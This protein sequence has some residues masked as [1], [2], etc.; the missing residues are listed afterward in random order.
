MKNLSNNQIYFL[1]KKYDIDGYIKIKNLL[2]KDE[3]NEIKSSLFKFI[4]KKSK[5]FSGRDVSFVKNSKTINSIH[6][7]KKWGLIKKIQNNQ[8]IK[9]LAKI[10]IGENI[11]NFGAEIF[12]KPA[13][14]GL[15]APIHQDNHYWHVQTEKKNFYPNGLGLTIWIALEES[16]K[17]NG[18]V[19]Y[20]KK[21]HKVGLLEH[22]FLKKHSGLSQEIKYKNLLKLFKKKTPELNIGDALIHNCMIIHGSNPNKSSQS[23]LGLT[24][25]YVS[26]NS[27]INEYFKNKYDLELKKLKRIS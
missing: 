11:K 16:K 12:A 23:R 24:M 3:I 13:K 18:A 19:F 17:K 14:K 1:K 21:S 20:F 2:T 22:V 27:F 15:Q 4:E 7:L 10:M 26:K 8:K 25:R 9:K 5:N 6:N